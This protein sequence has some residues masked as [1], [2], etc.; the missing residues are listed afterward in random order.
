MSPCSFPTTITI[1]PRVAEVML[2]AGV[3][4]C[5]EKKNGKFDKNLKIRETIVVTLFSSPPEVM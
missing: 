3:T 5:I 4:I 2:G 1:T